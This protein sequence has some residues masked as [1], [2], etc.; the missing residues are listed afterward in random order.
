MPSPWSWTASTAR[1]PV[2]VDGDLDRL[3]GTVLDGV[4]EQV[5]DHLIEA[6]GIPGPH[7]P[8]RPRTSSTQP[9]RCASSPRRVRTSSTTAD[10]IDLLDLQLQPAGRDARHV[11]QLVDQV[12]EPRRLGVDPLRA[13][14]DAPG[15]LPGVAAGEPQQVLHLQP[16][17]GERRPQLVR[18]DGEEILAQADR[19][20][21]HLLGLLLIIDVGRGG[22]PACNCARRRRSPAPAPRGPGASG[23]FRQRPDAAGSAARRPP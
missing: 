4:R 11:E 8:L 20:A 10:Q 22:D 17:R 5:G 18:G 9:R 2:D 13:L 3:A 21:Q 23:T 6:T 7:G 14:D 19:L 1:S 12:V 15:R 16:Q